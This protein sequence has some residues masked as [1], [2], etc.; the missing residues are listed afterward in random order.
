MT[1]V[2]D[3]NIDFDAIKQHFKAQ[4]QHVS[5]LRKEP[6]SARKDR[7]RKLKRW[8]GTNRSA[9]HQ[10]LYAD[11]SKPASE[12]DG[13]EI[14][15]ALNEISHALSNLN[16]WVAPKK[17]DAP[18]TML[19]TRSRLEYEP[20]GVCLIISPWNY[21]FNLSIG[22]LVS[23]L[24][25]GNS[26]M[27]KPS[28][29]TPNTSALIKRLGEE[30]FDS[31]VVRVIEGDAKISSFLLSLPF[32]HIFFTGSP[33]VGKLVMKAAAE[34][35]ASVTLELGG[36]SP[37]IVTPGSRL[38]EAAKRIAV[39]KFINKGQ[40][41]IAPDYVLV[42]HSIAD[43]FIDQLKKQIMVLFSESGKP[44]HESPHLARIVSDKHFAR[45]EDSIADAVMKGAV[46]QMSGH[47][48]PSTRF[49]HPVILSNVSPEARVMEEEIFGPVLPIQTYTD[50]EEVI[51]QINHKPKPLALYMFGADSREQK[52]ILTETSSGSVCINDC[53]IQFLHQ[54]LP[55][56][57]VNN[58]GIGRSHGY[59]GFL[60]FS[61]EKP[62]LSQRSGFTSVQPLYPPYT[63]RVKK[64]MDILLKMI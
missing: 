3:E 28:E 10:A 63:S 8:I 24:A 43:Q 64:I 41:C 29:I 27:L 44:L 22:P 49:I 9:I 31:N 21:P 40:T 62:V 56:G 35:L 55:F 54:N 32:D 26:V 19:G 39:A 57:G 18:L 20:R 25:A 16:R 7:L 47:T 36:K 45:L 4:K 61:H 60:A 53:A 48:D 11:F 2:I 58:S 33:A 46:V 12:V 34:N 6:V 14:F 15:P 59:Y 17:V 52:K 37:A 13:T 42:H 50:L 38:P 1:P 5:Q 23:A 51:Q 30:V